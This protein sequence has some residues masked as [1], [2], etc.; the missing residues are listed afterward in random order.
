MRRGIGIP[1]QCVDDRR[2]GLSITEVI[3]VR[4]L[5]TL[6]EKECR[7]LLA[8]RAAVHRSRLYNQIIVGPE[9]RVRQQGLH[10]GY[11]RIPLEIP[12]HDPEIALDGVFG[13]VQP[14]DQRRVRYLRS[15]TWNFVR[16][17]A[18]TGDLPEKVDQFRRDRNLS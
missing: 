17:S 4:D 7:V 12:G 2:R 8:G 5:A 10:P 16:V 11:H 13:C 9:E 3:E 6:V 18:P 1:G 14:A 15:Q